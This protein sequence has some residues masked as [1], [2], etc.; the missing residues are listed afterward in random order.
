MGIRINFGVVIILD[1]K[2]GREGGR[3]G[4]RETETESYDA[5]YLLQLSYCLI[6]SLLH[7][8]LSSLSGE[9]TSLLVMLATTRLKEATSLQCTVVSNQC[10][11]IVCTHSQSTSSIFFLISLM[12]DD[13]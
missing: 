4:G 11:I 6:F 1:G 8:K 9:G 2:G 7:D 5:L 10:N 3:G 13:S 12:E